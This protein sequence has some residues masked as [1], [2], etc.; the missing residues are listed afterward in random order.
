MLVLERNK[1][2]EI[3]LRTPG[4]EEM[5]IRINHVRGH[6]VWLGIRAPRNVLVDRRETYDRRMS[7]EQLPDTY[8]GGEE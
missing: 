8:H 6:K 7:A 2:E 1:G 4:G 5:V 3:V